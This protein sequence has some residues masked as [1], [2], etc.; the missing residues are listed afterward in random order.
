MTQN[1]QSLKSTKPQ[2]HPQELKLLDKIGLS[3]IHRK[4]KIVLFRTR[5]YE[6]PTNKRN[7]V[8]RPKTTL[9]FGKLEK[10][11]VTQKKSSC[12]K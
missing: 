3:Q 8:R 6:N 1:Y 2:Q 10:V 12:P 11:L 5:N 7:W 4:Q 9:N